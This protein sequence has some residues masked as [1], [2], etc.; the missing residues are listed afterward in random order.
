MERKVGFKEALKMFWKNYVNFKGRSRRSEYWYMVL[1]HLIFMAPAL[2]LYFFALIFLASGAASNSDG[3]LAFGV[4]LMFLGIG[5]SAI[6]SLATLVPN[7]A[8]MIR[9]FHDTGRTMLIPLIFL[10]VFVVTYPITIVINIRDE[11]LTNPINMVLMIL[12]SLIYF[13]F[14]IFMIVIACLD[15][16]RKTNKYGPSHKYGNHIPASNK[17]TKTY[18]QNQSANQTSN[19]STNQAA[20]NAQHNNNLNEENSDMKQVNRNNYPFGEHQDETKPSS[21]HNNDHKY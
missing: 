3:M 15:S 11:Q 12:I 6:Y 18:N 13:G 2:V 10:G 19:Q 16:E 7:W 9:R 8:I 1:W 4:I 20:N 14:S 21:N 17:D 5:Y